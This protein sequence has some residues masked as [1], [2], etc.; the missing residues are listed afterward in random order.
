MRKW[1]QMIIRLRRLGPLESLAQYTE[2]RVLLYS[3]VLYLTGIAIL[4]WLRPALMFKKNGEWKEF[5]MNNSDTTIFP[6]W[7]FCTVWAV[8]TYAVVS[9]LVTDE[10][11]DLIKSAST[12]SSVIA[13]V[14][15]GT[16]V[17]SAAPTLNVTP[18]ELGT[19]AATPEGDTARPGYYKLSETV[20]KKKGVPRYIYIGPEKPEDME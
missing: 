18:E 1:R 2:M 7:L 6:F 4:L 3:M 9:S 19:A 10:Y 8:V 14:Q 16:P 20:L 13:S 15:S 17:P 5:G 12:A 11:M